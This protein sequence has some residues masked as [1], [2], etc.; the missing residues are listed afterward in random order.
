MKKINLN[1][2]TKNSGIIFSTIFVLLILLIAN[3][4]AINGIIGYGS[5]NDY[6]NPTNTLSGSVTVGSGETLTGT[7]LATINNAVQLTNNGISV[8]IPSN[9]Q[10]ANAQGTSFNVNSIT[11][12]VLNNLPVAL[13]TN[14]LD[15]GKIK[16]GIDGVNLYFSK[17]VKLQIPVN[18]TNSTVKIYSKHA[19]VSGYQTYSLTDTLASNCNNGYASPSSNIATVSNGIATIYTCSASDFIASVT[20]TQTNSSSGGGGTGGGGGGSLLR[21]DNCP[22]G[23]YS[24]SYYDRECGIAPLIVNNLSATGTLNDSLNNN[25]KNLNNG[26]KRTIDYKGINIV[27][28]EGYKLSNKT[29]LVAKKIIE[30]KKLTL[31]EKN[32]YINRV[33]EFLISKYNFDI[34][35]KNNVTLK[36]NY[37][38]QFFLLKKAIKDF[39]NRK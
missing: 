3:T 32:T 25:E 21:M 5:N 27:V 2:I 36:N 35:N 38:K 39:S 11:T 28:I 29:A 1:R 33:N 24:K 16:F 4:S 15:V 26:T 31:V 6:S 37:I 17:P 34:S 20:N 12:Y 30:N 7:T 22:K 18:T 10:I 9:T 19:G 14:E 13:S 8:T 23:D